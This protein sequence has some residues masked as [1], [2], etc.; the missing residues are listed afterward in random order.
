MVALRSAGWRPTPFR[1]FIVKLHS[2]C[3]LACTYCYIYEM[4]DSTWRSAPRVADPVTLATVARRIADHVERH[5]LPS[6]DVVFHG[7]EPLLVGSDAIAAAANAMRSAM[8]TTCSLRMSVQT[9]ALL[10]NEQVLDVLHRHQVR[11]GVSLDGSAEVHDRHRVYAD[12]RGSHAGVVRA[13]RL[14]RTPVHVSLYAGLLCTIDV[15]SDPV[16]TYRSLLDLEPPML[17]FLLPHGN[18][19]SPPPRRDPRSADPVYGRWLATAFDAW[20]ARPDTRIRLFEQVLDGLLGGQ[21]SS[22]SVGISPVGVLVFDTAGRME[23]VDS[24]RS[25]G[26]D[27]AA[28]GMDVRTHSLDEALGHPGVVARQIGTAALP[29]SCLDCPIH[30]VCGAGFYPHRYRAGTGYRNPSVY[31]P[32]LLHLIQHIQRRLSSQVPAPARSGR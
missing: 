11:V 30:R 3:N 4:G 18:W 31:C 26:N 23:Q 21:S 29:D 6:V 10:L 7:G 2:R 5:R 32:D 1:Q 27:A 19:T 12:G 20:T 28:V 9:N 16:S 22:E 17:D 8:P 25:V 14:L 24:L 15:S 13:L